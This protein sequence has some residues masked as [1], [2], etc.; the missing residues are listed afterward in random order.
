LLFFQ[1]L[2]HGPGVSDAVGVASSV[3]SEVFEAVGVGG[4]CVFVGIGVS[5]AVLV[6]NGVVVRVGVLVGVGVFVGVI[7]GVRVGVAVG[8]G[9]GTC[10][11][12]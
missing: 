11:S 8:V 7:V 1:I 9:V 12:N 3:G 10:I 5:V 4:T 6:G 2:A